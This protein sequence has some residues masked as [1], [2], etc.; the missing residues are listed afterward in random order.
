MP[1]SPPRP[2]SSVSSRRTSGT[3][4][5]V[6]VMMLENRSFDHIFGF[7]PGVHGLEGTELNLLDPARPASATNR[8]FHVNGDG[9]PVVL[10]GEGPGHSVHATNV[11]LCNDKAGPRAGT[12]AANNG[13]VRSY[14]DELMFADKVRAP[15]DLM[16][17]VVMQ[18]LAP[19]QLPSAHAL[20]DAFC[21]CDNWYAEVP[22]PT[23]PNRLYMHAATSLGYAHNVWTK[24]FDARTIYGNLQEA[25]FTWATYEFDHNEV[26][27]FK[28]VNGQSGNFKRF[29][30]AF[31][32]DVQGGA[33]P[34]YAFI[35]PRFMNATNGPA[36]SQHAPEDPRYGDNFIADVY[37][38]LRRNEDVWNKS[39]LI[40]IHDEHGGFYDHVIPPAGVPNP[41]GLSSP[42]H[43]DPA[44]F[45]PV[46]DFSRLG[47][48]VPA[49]IVS[50]WVPAG[51]ID[52]TRYQHT[53]VL[54]TLKSMFGLP[55]FLSKRDASANPF[56]RLFQQL[57]A[58]RTDTPRT[59]PRADLPQ[60][61]A[62]LDDPAHPV[63]QLTLGSHPDGP[64]IDELP[65]T[66]GEAHRFIRARYE[67]HFGSRA[68]SRPAS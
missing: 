8:A 23:Q 21:L 58:P 63:N 4:E 6:I 51:K 31:A 25:G 18:S 43:G 11:Q 28:Q 46:F 2:G 27:E 57:P 65:N 15:T 36:N 38:A 52:S 47:L 42:P 54:A 13:F 44:S 40:V 10:A 30:D 45:A 61:P 14:K 29:E 34:N 22:G 32:A 68:T 17:E 35:L 41:D 37:E 60:L 33:L 62:S 56:D 55:T 59:L 24:Q 12:P 49:L 50:P 9:P 7:R 64:T 48:R 19:S 53:S 26:R 39:V 3:I 16:I 1:E 20:A 66:Q 5:H 67:R